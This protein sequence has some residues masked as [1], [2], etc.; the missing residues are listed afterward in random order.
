MQLDSKPLIWSLPVKAILALLLTL[1]TAW[2]GKAQWRYFLSCQ[3]DP[4]LLLKACRNEVSLAFHK[5]FKGN[6]GD[7]FERQSAVHIIYIWAWPSAQSIYTIF[8]FWTEVLLVLD[9]Y[10]GSRFTFSEPWTASS[11][12]PES[13]V[14]T[15]TIL[16]IL[17]LVLLSVLKYYS[18]PVCLH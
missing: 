13:G 18:V 9:V 2:V 5:L 14:A 7:A 15:I 4:I 17:L 6:N 12:F 16:I 3:V 8:K 1:V 10:C 11:A